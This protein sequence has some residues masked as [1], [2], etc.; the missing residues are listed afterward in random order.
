[1]GRWEIA[2]DRRA[3]IGSGMCASLAPDRFALDADQRSYPLT[4]RIDPDEN[5]SDAGAACPA[6]AI[7][8]TD[9]ATGA[10]VPLE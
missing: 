10:P 2:V 8:V 3:C 6:E 9:T 4:P 1:M 7:S 5:V